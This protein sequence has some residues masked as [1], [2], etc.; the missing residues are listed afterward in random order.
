MPYKLIVLFAVLFCLYA[1]KVSAQKSFNIKGSVTDS[2]SVPLEGANIRIISATDSFK[3]IS[4]TKGLFTFGDIKQQSFQ[5][6]VSYLGYLDFVKNVTFPD[7]GEELN[8][9]TII[10]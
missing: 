4:D 6:K 8:L 2:T 9:G 5:L 10:L 7:N 3:V 1:S